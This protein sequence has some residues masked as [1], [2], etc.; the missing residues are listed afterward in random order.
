M[1]CYFIFISFQSG[2]SIINKANRQYNCKFC[3]EEF[4]WQYELLKHCV[5]RHF[6]DDIK[7]DL[8]DEFPAKCPKC[9]FTG[10]NRST[11]VL[12]YG[13]T[14]RVIQKLIEDAQS[15]PE[16]VANKLRAPPRGATAASTSASASQQSQVE[17]PFSCPLCSLKVSRRQQMDHLC[18]HFSERL[19]QRLPAAGPFACPDCRFVGTDRRRLVRH[20]GGHHGHAHALLVEHL[21]DA[22][23]D[24][25]AA[26]VV[27]QE[28]V[29]S[30]G[31]T[32]RIPPPPEFAFECQLC[33]SLPVYK[34]KSELCKHLSESHFMERIMSELPPLPVLVSGDG[35]DSLPGAADGAEGLKAFKCN[36]PGCNYSS[37]TRNSLLTHVAVF[38]R[39]ALK[40]YLDV[41]GQ[42]EL[43]NDVGGDPR[44][45]W[46]DRVG[47][48]GGGGGGGR[49]A[50]AVLRRQQAAAA[51]LETPCAICGEKFDRS[52]LVHHVAE[53]HFPDKI[54]GLSR[55]APFKC[56]QCPHFAE[57]REKLLRH[58]GFY[59]KVFDK[60][61]ADQMKIEPTDAIDVKSE[62]ES[63]TGGDTPKTSD[64]QSDAG[65]ATPLHL[66]EIKDEI[67]TEVMEKKPE[68][69]AGS[70]PAANAVAGEE[71]R[72]TP[73]LGKSVAQQ[74]LMC[75][76]CRFVGTSTTDFHKHLCDVHFKERLIALV[77]TVQGEAGKRYRCPECGYEHQYRF[78]IAR[79]CGLKH[80][81]A[82][83]FYSEVTGEKFDPELE[84]AAKRSR[85]RP[86]VEMA[87]MAA[88]DSKSSGTDNYNC[89]IC[90]A[91]SLGLADYLKHLSKI[92]FKSKLLSMVP[93]TEPFICP[94][95]GCG[96][97]KKDH[98]ALAVHY[99]INHKEWSL[100]FH[101]GFFEQL[102]AFCLI[103]MSLDMVSVS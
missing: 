25:T 18:T 28:R 49:S 101:F 9:E 63:S 24:V 74:C 42:S 31:E 48:G 35:G 77:Q 60:I 12:H 62:L 93:S 8:P 85:G 36:R 73:T 45:G 21:R 10:R 4:K 40:L 26:D 15:N 66:P 22:G 70:N 90:S 97:E 53:T 7:K 47:H 38:H 11:L 100:D 61:T 32:T 41:V 69:A 81:F 67:M 16:S 64:A 5:F 52:S 55:E 1:N 3:S 92:H 80:L 56:P 83:K 87:L 59:H 20:Y 78:Q 96:L 51:S 103:P 75:D 2:V 98:L 94:F 33:D 34:N 84:E 65:N 79:H 27:K 71:S 88:I 44:L 99:G 82:K 13:V 46:D 57:N 43:P 95:D 50:E 86:T 58:F 6:L 89:K 39:V 17:R 91:R 68:D 29:L 19:S 37:T 30:G 23:K 102:F 72:T 54:A 14:H 76:D